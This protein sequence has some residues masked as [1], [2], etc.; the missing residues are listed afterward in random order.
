M[1]AAPAAASDQTSHGPTG[2]GASHLALEHGEIVSLP[3]LHASPRLPDRPRDRLHEAFAL[4][5]HLIHTVPSCRSLFDDL[6]LDAHTALDFSI[7][8]PARVDHEVS[9]CR[10]AVAFS[11]VG[12]GPTRLCRSFADLDLERAVEVVLHE[13]LHRAGLTEHGAKPSGLLPSQIDALVHEACCF[14]SMAPRPHS[15]DAVM[16]RRTTPQ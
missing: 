6:E 15:T 13:A 4:A 14:D 11:Y 2:P 7:Y 12:A 9:L 1:L 8:Y 3:V 10:R 5:S 16:V